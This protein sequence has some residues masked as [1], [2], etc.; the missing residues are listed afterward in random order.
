MD[1]WQMQLYDRCKVFLEA[2]DCATDPLK[3]SFDQKDVY[4][5]MKALEA[6]EQY[7]NP[8]VAVGESK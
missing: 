8:L 1:I 4:V 7:E 5:I 3:T 2:E 6:Q